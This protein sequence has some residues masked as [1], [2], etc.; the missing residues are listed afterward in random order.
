MLLVFGNLAILLWTILA[1]F[2]FWL[3]YPIL[4]WIFLLLALAMVFFLLRRL[5]CSSCY[6]CKS[7][8]SGFGRLAGWFFGRR[9]LKDVNDDRV[10]IRSHHLLPSSTHSSVVSRNFSAPRVRSAQ[11]Y[12]AVVPA[13]NFGLQCRHVAQTAS[14]NAISLSHRFQGFLGKPVYSG[15][16]VQVNDDFQEN[17]DAQESRQFSC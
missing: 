12:C 5:G 13:A 8:T 9:E 17:H 2:A 4:T 11:D 15:L 16:C 1:A 10:D 3:T 14:T 6:N 7:C